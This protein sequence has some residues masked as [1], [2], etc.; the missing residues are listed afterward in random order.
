MRFRN[1]M[2]A[3]GLILAGSAS[4]Q[5]LPRPAEFYFDDDSATRP[6]IAVKSADPMPRLLRAVE[7]DP[8]AIAEAA[9]LAHIAA[10]GGQ[11][12]S[13]EAYY[14]RALRSLDTSS[15]LWRPV[16]WNYAWDLYRSGRQD[17]AL[18]RWSTLVAA[19]DSK[20]AWI[21][22]TLA[23]ALWT[24][25]RKDEAVQ[26]YAAAVRSEPQLWASAGNLPRLLPD[27]RDDER[28]TLA[29]VQAEW[30]AHPPKWP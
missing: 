8:A 5:S 18:Q 26:W 27:W 20:A 3:A 4:A 9:Q 21:P 16:M 25:G 10:T 15:G 11:A 2:V 24:A 22:P 1:L 29:Q 19:R 12:D 6:V 28:A 7:R 30:A 14:Q 23:L 17:A 13:A